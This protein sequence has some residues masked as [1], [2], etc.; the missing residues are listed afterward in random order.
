MRDRSLV[1]GSLTASML[2]VWSII[3]L[4]TGLDREV[5]IAGT[6]ATPLAAFVC[7]L[8]WQGRQKTRIEIANGR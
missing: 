7:Y 4:K 6:L 3:V 2:I 1:V 5:R 8:W